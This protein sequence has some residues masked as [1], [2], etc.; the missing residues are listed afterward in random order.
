[1]AIDGSGVTDAIPGAI[2]AEVRTDI[3]YAPYVQRQ[4]NEAARLKGDRTALAADFDY[5]S[6]AGLSSE[7]IERLSL[8]RPD[9][10]Q[11][12]SRIQ[13]ITPAALTALLIA[14]KAAA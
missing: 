11:Q 7:M 13:G 6:I 2:L 9:S 10:V 5:A 14:A 1:M 8:S 3:Q 12:A 4:V